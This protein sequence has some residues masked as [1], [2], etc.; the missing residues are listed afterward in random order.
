[1]TELVLENAENAAFSDPRSQFFPIWND[2]KPTNNI[3]Q[4][5]FFFWCENVVLD[6]CT[7][8]GGN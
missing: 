4:V 6:I 7:V 2:P 8:P 1:M 5:F 3:F